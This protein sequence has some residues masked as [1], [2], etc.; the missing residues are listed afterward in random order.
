MEVIISTKQPNKEEDNTEQR[1]QT[2]NPIK[3]EKDENLIQK[4]IV[5]D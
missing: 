3:K 4:K 2:E 5:T 1:Y